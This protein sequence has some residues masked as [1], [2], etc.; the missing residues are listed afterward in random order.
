[1]FT[2]TNGRVRMARTS[3]SRSQ[4]VLAGAYGTIITLTPC[5]KV[6][7]GGWRFLADLL[8]H[9]TQESDVWLQPP[10]MLHRTDPVPEV[11][12][13]LAGVSETGA[14]RALYGNFFLDTPRD[15]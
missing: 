14:K 5:G 1:M 11:E 6:A 15:R 13:P 4:G 7:Q 3:R 10:S 12:P 2:P 9:G 8:A